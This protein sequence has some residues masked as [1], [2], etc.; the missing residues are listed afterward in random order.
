MCERDGARRKGRMS[1]QPGDLVERGLVAPERAEELRRVAER[2]SVAITD[3]MAALIDP[4]RSGRPDRGAI[5]ARCR[6]AERQ[7]RGP[8]RPDRRRSSFAGARHRPSLSGPGAAEADPGVPGLLPLLLPPRAGRAGRGGAGPR[9]ARPRLRL[10]RSSIPKSGRSI[11]TGGDPFLLSPRRIARN[12]AAARRDSAC[13]GD[14]LS[15]PR[16][17]RRAGAGRGRA[18]R[19]AERPRRRSMS[20]F[21]P[22]TR[23]S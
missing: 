1:A 19:G 15:Y 16:A 12:R 18:G 14:P 6:R 4:G 8:A 10:Y 21:T 7:P 9:R 11:V 2:F 23:A 22:T 3:D 17:G 5:R 13:R 20:S